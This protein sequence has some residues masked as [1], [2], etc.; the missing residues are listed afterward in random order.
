M[1]QN[2]LPF[3]FLV[4]V[5]L[6]GCG[7]KDSQ[8]ADSASTM[9]ANADTVGAMAGIQKTPARDADQEF[10]QMMVDHHQGMIEMAD[11]ALKKAASSRV[12]A[13][14]TSML[15]AQKAEQK[16][17]LDVLKTQ[18]GE[19]KVPMALASDASMVTTLAGASGAAFDR[20]FREQVIM[21]HEEAIKM[22]DQF[23][24]RLKT[25]ALKQMAEKMKR[26]QAT[27]IAELRKELK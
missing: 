4:V 10:M 18:Y 14:A 19:D 8:K 7:K 22:V 23:L 3:A 26:D 24:P 17:M 27:Q 5:L 16:R 13:E 12:R 21:H 9:S 25:P 11:T 1:R 15:A 20:Q 6:A 2:N